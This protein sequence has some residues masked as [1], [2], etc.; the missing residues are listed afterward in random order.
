MRLTTAAVV[1]A[2]AGSLTACAGPGNTPSGTPTAKSETVTL[3][4]SAAPAPPQVVPPPVPGT[5]GVGCDGRRIQPAQ[6]KRMG[7][8]P[9]RPMTSAE[10]DAAERA[11][12][13]LEAANPPLPRRGPLPSAAAAQAET[14][15]RNL[16]PQLNLL[17]HAS[18]PLDEQ[19]LR[20][21][22]TREGLTGV[23]IGP[24]PNFAAATGTAC[25]HGSL[26]GERPEMSI[27]P[28]AP[29]GTCH[30]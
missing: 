29:D 23:A 28:P 24:G 15:A 18:G 7:S 11:R 22:L 6:P 21:L 16:S 8:A 4:A 10:A 12:R 25:V 26:A 30:P 13:A 5:P 2:L 9:P 20:A 3:W 17:M 27:G 1:L 19:T 14:C